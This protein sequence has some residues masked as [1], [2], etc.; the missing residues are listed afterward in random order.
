MLYICLTFDY[1]LFLGKNN[2]TEKE[3][4]FDPTAKLAKMLSQEN[5]PA[6]F[7]ADICSAIQY[8]KVGLKEYTGDFERQLQELYAEGHD[9]QLHIH[10]HW[11]KS[12]YADG[13][14]RFDYKSYR[15]HSFGFDREKENNNVY[16]VLQMGIERLNAI[17]NRVDDKYQCIAY[18]AGGFA[19][20]PHKE[21]VEALY[22][23]G[24]KVDSSIA[25]HLSSESKTNF[26]NYEEK[27]MQ[28]NWWISPDHEWWENA[29]QDPK[30]LYEIPI[31]TENK[32]PLLFGL[33]RALKPDTIKLSLGQK[34][35]SYVNS[36]EGRSGRTNIWK[37]LS[38]YNAISLDAYQADFLYRQIL[39]YYREHECGKK[40]VYA[41]VIGHPKLVTDIYVQNAK[42]FI[43][44]I[45][46]NNDIKLMSII[47]IYRKKISQE[48]NL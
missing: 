32:N 28:A 2:F 41:A 38:G 15:I 6:T 1:E 5:V 3:I 20:Q 9:V 45:K 17:L 30:A 26:Y 12:S 44:L 7:F 11:L 22:D 13:T 4:L 27:N 18:R 36:E 24:I 33:R 31:A 48:R 29:S 42:K 16:D 43:E 10:P 8:Q 46:G 14:W 21:L 23:S 47:D 19:L 35:G 40:D 37:Y 39:R 25:P 34:K